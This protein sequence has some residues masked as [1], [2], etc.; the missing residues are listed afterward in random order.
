MT[1]E[2]SALDV[3]CGIGGIA[4]NLARDAGEVLGIEVVEDAVRNARDNARL[5]RLNNCRFVAGDAAELLDD[6]LG[7]LP[8][9]FVATV[10][11][12]RKGCDR[13]V[14]DALCAL[15]PRALIYVSCNPES[16]AV[17][18]DHLCRNGWQVDK[19]Q[20]VDM[21]PQSP[22]VETVVRLLPRQ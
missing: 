16:L 3:Y 7:E 18:L 21:C 4:L 17:D 12:P 8:P 19:V 13:E 11:P 10:N 22:H 1:P 2:Q 6:L 20:P 9:G 14:L 5:N 15:Q